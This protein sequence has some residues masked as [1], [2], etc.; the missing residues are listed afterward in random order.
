MSKATNLSKLQRVPLR[1]AWRHEAGEFT[2]WLAE[3]ENLNEL[4]ISIEEEDRW[5]EYLDWI[6]QRLIKMDQV[7]RPIVRELP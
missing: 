7:F 5:D 1:E 4:Q 2:P 3:P 6:T